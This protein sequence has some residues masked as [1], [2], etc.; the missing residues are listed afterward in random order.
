MKFFKWM[1]MCVSSAV[2]LSTAHGAVDGIEGMEST[3]SLTLSVTLDPPSTATIKITGLQD[4]SFMKDV[5][6]PAASSVSRSACV[7]MSEPGEFDVLITAN[8]L[9][10]DPNFYDYKLEVSDGT[11]QN[12][13]E[14]T[15]SNETKTAELFG[16][17]A[18]TVSGCGADDPLQL[19][20]Y[21]QGDLSTAFSAQAQIS[22]RV[23]PD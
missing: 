1:M 2:F 15:V 10:A 8:P 20:F 22:L 6:D 17:T 4:V 9:T 18:S 19:V 23:K 12:S 3:A 21:D 14:I 13:V 7:Y 16:I 11:A 5:G